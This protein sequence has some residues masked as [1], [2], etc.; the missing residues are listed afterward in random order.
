MHT[1]ESP[2]GVTAAANAGTRS[3]QSGRVRIGIAGATGFT[4]QELLRLLSR[5]PGVVVTTAT[6]SGTGPGRR[7]PALNRIWNGTLTPL[8]P[9]VLVQ[10]SDVVFLA[11]P[12]TA[13]AELAPKLI[14]QGVRAIDLSGAFRLQDAGLRARWYP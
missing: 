10:E 13:A 5:H 6:S 12:D 1:A 11:L 9:D 7:R 8:D 14:E 3:T 2:R 4:G